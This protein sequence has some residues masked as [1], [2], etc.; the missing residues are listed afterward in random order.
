MFDISQ[1]EG[2]PLP[3]LETEAHGDPDGLVEDLLDATDEIG[4]DARI[5]APEEWEHGSAR[6]V[7]ERRN[8]MTTNPMVEAVD[9]DNRAALA[10]TLIHEFAHAELH[11]DVDDEAERSKREVEAEAVATWSVVTSVGPRQLGVL[12]RGVGRRR[13]RDAAGP[14]GPYL[15]DCG[16][17][18]RRRRRCQLSSRSCF[19]RRA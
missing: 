11:F 3:E 7:C 10:S 5:V 17:S 14:V 2:E 15:V 8:V 13:T 16:G 4:V 1:T 19:F 18:D 9:R 6:G 12:P